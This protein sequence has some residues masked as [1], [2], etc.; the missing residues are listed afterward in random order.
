MLRFPR[1]SATPSSKPPPEEA[2]ASDQKRKNSGL[3]IATSPLCFALRAA[4]FSRHGDRPMEI[5][6]RC[7]KCGRELQ[8]PE[9]AVGEKGTC[10]T[11]GKRFI[12]AAPSEVPLPETKPP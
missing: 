3:V 5:T 7:T 6:V 8:A 9:E 2:D 4:V 11:C 1:T 10:P 12:I